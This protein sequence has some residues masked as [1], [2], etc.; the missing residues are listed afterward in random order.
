VDL[1]RITSLSMKVALSYICV[2]T[3]AFH[4]QASSLSNTLESHFSISLTL[5]PN[6][7]VGVSIL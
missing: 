5:K 3:I 2:P 7:I 1:Q 6:V 4:S